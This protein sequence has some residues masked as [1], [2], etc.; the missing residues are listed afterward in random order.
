MTTQSE[1]V[2]LKLAVL[3]VSENIT[4]PSNSRNIEGTLQIVD[5]IDSEETTYTGTWSLDGTSL[6][7]EY[8]E[9]SDGN[10]VIYPTAYTLANGASSTLTGD[11]VVSDICT[12]Y[13]FTLNN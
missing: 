1:F 3:T 10:A 11:I 2:P 7:V 8:D 6:T 13:T 9:T 12:Q 5:T 4:L